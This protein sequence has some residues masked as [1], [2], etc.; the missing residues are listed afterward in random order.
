MMAAAVTFPALVDARF[1]PIGPRPGGE[2]IREFV[3]CSVPANF[4]AV[5]SKT[6]ALRTHKYASYSPAWR[7][8]IR[9]LVVA[10]IAAPA[11]LF[12]RG[13]GSGWKHIQTFEHPGAERRR[14]VAKRRG[15]VFA[16]TRLDGLGVASPD[17]SGRDCRK[18]TTDVR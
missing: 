2:A 16:K 7:T 6:S 13:A 10:A 5:W 1:R 14:L 18:G 3:F 9:A 4:C 17:A 15:G 11:F 8:I 12:R